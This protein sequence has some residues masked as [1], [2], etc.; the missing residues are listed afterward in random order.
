MIFLTILQVR[1]TTVLSFIHQTKHAWL[2]K[3]QLNASCYISSIKWHKSPLMMLQKHPLSLLGCICKV[4][5][6]ANEQMKV[7]SKQLATMSNHQI[8][9]QTPLDR[10]ENYFEKPYAFITIEATNHHMELAVHLQ[11]QARIEA[12]GLKSNNRSDKEV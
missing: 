2:D 3:T 11:L 6:K 10:T 8:M 7:I 12:D 9:T 5:V 1:K 4:F